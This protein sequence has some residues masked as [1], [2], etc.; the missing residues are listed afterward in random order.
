MNK[1]RREQLAALALTLLLALIS[2]VVLL[3]VKV[4]PVQLSTADAPQAEDAEVFFADIDVHE[5][6]SDPTPQVDGLPASAA[7]SEDGGLDMQDL[8][9]GPDAPQP[10]TQSEPA[11][12]KTAKPAPEPDPGPTQEEI[13]AQKAAAIRA[14]IGKSSGL[15]AKTD[16][17]SGSAEKGNAV[18]GHNKTSDGLG[19]DGRKRLNSPDPAIRNASGTVKV[20]ITVDS[21]GSV[22]AAQ[23]VASSGF[24]QREE[25]VRNSCLNASKALRYS[26]S[27]DR[28]SQHGTITWVIK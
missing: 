18:T 5:I 6:L 24:G 25:E 1:P 19:L 9:N 17:G 28:P 15:A 10:V 3:V 20:R 22:T 11:P 21:S 12:E 14:R 27:A 2:T 8:G 7:A 13:N 26:P 4:E 16:N 23:V